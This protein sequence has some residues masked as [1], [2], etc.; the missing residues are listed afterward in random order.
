VSNFSIELTERPNGIYW[1]GE[2]TRGLLHLT[3]T[4]E[5]TCRSVKMKFTCNGTT[6]WHYTKSDG[7]G[8]SET[9][10]VRGHKNYVAQRFAA[11]GNFYKTA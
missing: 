1:T 11:W 8:G 9:V 2:T 6:H 3:T 10:H 4:K 5:I 7:D